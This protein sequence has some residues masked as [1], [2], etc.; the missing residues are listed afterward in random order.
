[1][2]PLSFVGLPFGDRKSGR[3]PGK[4]T[5]RNFF[6][7]EEVYAADLQIHPMALVNVSFSKFVSVLT[8]KHLPDVDD[9]YKPQIDQCGLRG[10]MH[11]YVVVDITE[12][13]MM[14]KTMPYFLKKLRMH[15]PSFDQTSDVYT[16]LNHASSHNHA[17]HGFQAA[18]RQ[19]FDILS[20]IHR[21]Y[22]DDYVHICECTLVSR[23][24]V[25][26]LVDT[27]SL[28]RTVETH[29]APGNPRHG[30]IDFLDDG[31]RVRTKCVRG[32]K[33]A[34][35]SFYYEGGKHARTE[36]EHPHPNDGITVLFEGDGVVR[37]V[38]GPRHRRNGTVEVIVHG[39][40]VRDEYGHTFG[41]VA[42]RDTIDYFNARCERVKTE[43]VHPH[44]EE[45]RTLYYEGGVHVRTEFA[46]GHRR[47]GIVEFVT[48]GRA[49]GRI[50][51]RGS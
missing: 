41:D 42:K 1:M 35:A 30:M 10:N 8:S 14:Q 18:L 51:Y 44:A 24:A 17:T 50:A 33:Q 12:D 47:H 22:A 45:G 23:G 11:D 26:P 43:Y 13:E 9:H 49:I 4:V 37:N 2:V 6:V 5:G 7:H 28:R 48:D 31:V 25:D 27:L 36:F 16:A 40:C 21:A 38:Y 39:R 15:S 20:A 34:G 46:S 3:Y 29:F 32:H 19:S